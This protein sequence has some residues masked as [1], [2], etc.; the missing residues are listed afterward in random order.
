MPQLQQKVKKTIIETERLVLRE[1]T[2]ADKEELFNLHSRPEVQQYTGEPLVKSIAEMEEAI[3]IRIDD[4]K[5]YGYGRWAAFLK[6]EMQFVGWAG[7][8]YLPE[9]D[10]IDL[11]YRFLAEYWGL[12]LAT[13]ASRAILSYGFDHLK[14]KRIV[15][16]AMKEHAASI[17]VMEKVGMK[18]EKF[19]PY[20]EGSEDAVWY[21]CYREVD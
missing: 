16:I 10:E 18:F 6:D 15:A 21:C 20:E 14:L 3:Q 9:F 11:G 7:L 4:Y 2:L 17:R 19:A 12:G 8:A 5:K 13:E 1:I